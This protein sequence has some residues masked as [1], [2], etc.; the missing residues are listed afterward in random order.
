[1]HPSSKS[2]CIR[3]NTALITSIYGCKGM[4]EVYLEKDKI[5]SFEYID[6]ENGRKTYFQ[7]LT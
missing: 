5:F 3:K 1:M 7:Y 4:Q 6:F 2:K